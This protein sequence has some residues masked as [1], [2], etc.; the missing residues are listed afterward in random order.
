MFI[1]EPIYKSIKIET[2][3]LERL[4]L[5][6]ERNID[7]SAC[8]SFNGSNEIDEMLNVTTTPLMLD[9]ADSVFTNRSNRIQ[10]N[11]NDHM[12]MF[13]KRLVQN[14]FLL[15]RC[16]ICDALFFD[17][18]ELKLHYYKSQQHELDHLNVINAN[19]NNNNSNQLNRRY[20]FKNLKQ[21][22]TNSFNKNNFNFL[23]ENTNKET[24]T[25]DKTT[26]F[27]NI[28]NDLS[29]KK[30]QFSTRCSTLAN[31]NLISSNYQFYLNVNPSLIYINTKNNRPLICPECGI[32]F[33]AKTQFEKFRLHL[34]YECLFTSKY[35][36][37]QI[38]C[39]AFNCHYLAESANDFVAHWSKFHI[40]NEHQCDICDKKGLQFI[41]ENE[42]SSNS[43]HVDNIESN[44]IKNS[45]IFKNI[46]ANEEDMDNDSNASN[47]CN[48]VNEPILSPNTISEI[49]KHFFDKH[50]NL[51][52]TLKLVYRCSCKT[53]TNLNDDMSEQ[54]N[55]A[56]NTDCVHTTWKN[57][58]KHIISLIAKTLASLNCL[59][60]NKLVSN[61]EYQNH[62]KT[63]HN[64]DKICICPFC[65]VLK[66]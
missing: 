11:D 14:K 34:I 37:G 19:N 36:C 45:Q 43:N 17:L 16:S 54:I 57:C 20:I 33:D 25:S 12:K 7:F 60:C 46:I 13:L 1:F 6:K 31:M 61:N 44:T 5:S 8:I 24:L 62:L 39:S 52:V 38:K 21:R 48:V 42:T 27:V 40:K 53:S 55:G 22:Y 65:G 49:N 63:V 4:N 18:K 64:L 28:L 56:K 41:F 9:L 51:Q 58:H 59:M 26:L 50:R 3:T 15:F 66:E 29:L 30:L 47:D 23:N 35:D 10:Q 2:I 32:S